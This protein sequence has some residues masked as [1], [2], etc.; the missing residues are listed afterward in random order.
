MARCVS[1]SRCERRI[2][3]PSSS[4]KVPSHPAS[5]YA[6][7]VTCVRACVNPA[8]LFLGTKADNAKDMFD[9]GRNRVSHTPRPGVRGERNGRAK[10]TR[11]QALA[12]RHAIAAGTPVLAVARDHHIDWTT[13]RRIA[14]GVLWR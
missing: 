13:A 14:D 8:H 7:V 4:G 11:L 1:A 6:I 3:S 10:L 12:V 2:D 5:V 9:K